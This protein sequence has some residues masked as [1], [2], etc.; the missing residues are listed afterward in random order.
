VPKSNIWKIS[1]VLAIGLSSFIPKAEAGGSHKVILYKGP[2]TTHLVRLKGSTRCSGALIA[3]NRVLTAAHCVLSETTGEPLEGIEVEIKGETFYPKFVIFNNKIVESLTDDQQGFEV[4]YDAAVLTFDKNLPGVVVETSN[5]ISKTGSLL[6]LGYQPTWPDG[7]LERPKS[8][9]DKSHLKPGVNVF[10]MKTAA[11]ILVYKNLTI[12]KTSTRGNCGMIPGGSG[13]PLLQKIGGITKVVGVLS[14]VN[15]DLTVNNWVRPVD[16][17]KVLKGGEGVVIHSF[18]GP[19]LGG[20][21]Y[22][23]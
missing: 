15:Q 7:S 1:V 23:S 16:Y 10:V 19:I 22:K 9:G 20:P 13:G 5:T 6:A 2:E 8:Y 14:T 3:K 4:M 21:P 18:S 11:C 17:N 12:G